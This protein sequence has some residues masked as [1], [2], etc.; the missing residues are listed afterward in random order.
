MSNED[1]DATAS[2]LD[3]R[4]LTHLEG[5][6]ILQRAVPGG[7]V[8]GRLPEWPKGAVCKTVGSAYVGSNPTPATSQNPSSARD[9]MLGSASD[10]C[11][12]MPRNATVSRWAWDI[13]GMARPP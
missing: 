6:A 7:T 12:Q 1:S 4:V 2:R 8:Y 11:S 10:M 9:R 3:A 13:R 5:S